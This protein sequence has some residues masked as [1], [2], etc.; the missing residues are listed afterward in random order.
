MHPSDEHG[1]VGNVYFMRGMLDW[2]WRIGVILT[3]MLYWVLRKGVFLTRLTTVGERLG[4]R[5]TP[6]L[7]GSNVDTIPDVNRGDNIDRVP[8]RT[9]SVFG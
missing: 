3:R 2:V 4:K 1:G 9:S 7:A 5:G 8:S 6:L